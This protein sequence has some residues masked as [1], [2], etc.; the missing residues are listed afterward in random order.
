MIM[1]CYFFRVAGDL[2]AKE[3]MSDSLADLQR[4]WQLQIQLV[5]PALG[6]IILV[7]VFYIYSLGSPAQPSLLLVDDSNSTK[8]EKALAKKKA[9][10]Q[11]QHQLPKV[12]RVDNWSTT[13]MID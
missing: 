2:I 6:A 10:Q 3:K 9:K 1:N 5:L 11:Q 7:V 12:Y 4:Y 8:K 13:A